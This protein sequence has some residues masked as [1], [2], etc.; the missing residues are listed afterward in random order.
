[1]RWIE[2]YLSGRVLRVHVGGE[3][4]GAIPMHSGV[5]QD[6]LIGLDLHVGL[7]TVSVL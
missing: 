5:P 4:L 7:N 3:H 6:S 1:M 2:A